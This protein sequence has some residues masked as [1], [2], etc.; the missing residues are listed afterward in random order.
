[1]TVIVP[2]IEDVI[3][4]TRR[5]SLLGG[6]TIIGVTASEPR[7][8]PIPSDE[9]TIGVDFNNEFVVDV[10]LVEGTSQVTLGSSNNGLRRL[11]NLIIA[12]EA[13]GNLLADLFTPVEISLS[14]ANQ[15]TVI[16]R[17]KIHL[18]TVMLDEY[19]LVS[20]GVFH[21]AELEYHSDDGTWRDAFGFICNVNTGD[22]GSTSDAQ[23]GYIST[24]EFRQSTLRDLRYG[25]PLGWPSGEYVELGVMPLQR[26]IAYPI[27]LYTVVAAESLSIEDTG[28]GVLS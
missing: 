16:G 1:M 2:T 10:Y 11:D 14:T 3:D 19:H 6:G 5:E 26:A 9:G 12:S 8:I 27:F 21:I 15:L 7:Y 18:P 23:V 24:L 20:L 17:S 25:D 4:I 22:L 28:T 13:S